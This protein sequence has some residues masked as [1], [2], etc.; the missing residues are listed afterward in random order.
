VTGRNLS[1]VPKVGGQLQIYI[2]L[3]ATR[4]RLGIDE[5]NVRKGV[6]QEQKKGRV[7]ISGRKMDE[8]GRGDQGKEKRLGWS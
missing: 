2:I 6:I 1:K 4:N 7:T 8:G 3:G 5:S